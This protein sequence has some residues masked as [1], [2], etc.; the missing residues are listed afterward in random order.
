MGDV[1]RLRQFSGY[2][3]E[4]KN[5]QEF[6]LGSQLAATTCVRHTLE[7]ARTRWPESTGALYYKMNDNYP[8]ASWACVDWYGVP[9][10]NH[11]VIGHAFAPL[12][13]CVL[14]SSFDMAGKPASLP[15]HLMDDTDVLRAAK[16][17]TVVCSGV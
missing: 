5:L 6:I 8:A 3:S 1:E 4:G 14:F 12:H 17:W 13:A 11:Y 7:L 15:V 16:N 2:F 9:K 10:I